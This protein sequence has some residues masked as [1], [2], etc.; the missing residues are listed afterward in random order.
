M[1]HQFYIISLKPIYNII[2]RVNRGIILLEEDILYMKRKYLI[3]NRKRIPSQ[4][5]D[6]PGL[7]DILSDRNQRTCS[8]APK[9]A[10]D[11]KRN[12]LILLLRVNTICQAPLTRFSE[13]PLGF[14]HTA[15]ITPDDFVKIVNC[16]I[17]MSY[18]L[19]QS[20]G[21]VLRLVSWAGF[22]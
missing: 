2:S 21:N 10:A 1:L 7:V 15:L 16:P 12:S 11:Y 8:F 9:A 6:I 17:I 5:S 14:L 20:L 13:N 3:N 18:C 4:E 19:L 22:C